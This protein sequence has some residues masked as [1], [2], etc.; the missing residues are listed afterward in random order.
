MLKK[1]QSCFVKYLKIDRKESVA[2]SGSTT[3]GRE[4]YIL[5]SISGTPGI[6]QVKLPT[7]NQTKANKNLEI[8]D[9]MGK[10]ERNKKIQ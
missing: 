3:L 7:T 9:T 4:V 6:E 5:S 2:R 10:R 1:K 8:R